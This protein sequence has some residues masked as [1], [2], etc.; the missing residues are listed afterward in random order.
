[1]TTT[2][3]ARA[4]VHADL[5]EAGHDVLRTCNPSERNGAVTLWVQV[6]VGERR[7]GETIEAYERS[8]G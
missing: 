8:I 7:I 3:A 1:M 6:T 2:D 5:T 4:I